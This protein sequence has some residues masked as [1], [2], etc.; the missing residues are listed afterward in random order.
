ME[1]NR[2]T[3]T[4]KFRSFSDFYRSPMELDVLSNNSQRLQDRTEFTGCFQQQ[5]S[6]SFLECTHISYYK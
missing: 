1:E 2:K 3:V 4:V 5:Y 6:T